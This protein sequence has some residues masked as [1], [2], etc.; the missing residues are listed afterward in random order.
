[1]QIYLI[2]SIVILQPFVIVYTRLTP[3]YCLHLKNGVLGVSV[4]RSP[5]PRMHLFIICFLMPAAAQELCEIR[6]RQLLHASQP[7]RVQPD[8]SGVRVYLRGE[9]I[10]HLSKSCAELEADLLAETT[11]PVP[12]TP[13]TS[14]SSTPAPTVSTS[15]TPSTSSSDPQ[16]VQNLI[17]RADD[18]AHPV[19]TVTRIGDRVA[20]SVG[21]NYSNYSIITLILNLSCI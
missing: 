3:S 21:K 14:S 4:F 5:W 6:A 10:G 19:I 8:S 2:A 12:P 15:P 7:V 9:V 1:M 16:P 17:T 11:S 13:T 20:I 18:P